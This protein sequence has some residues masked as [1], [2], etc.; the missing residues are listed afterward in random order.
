MRFTYADERITNQQFGEARPRLCDVVAGVGA[1]DR[2]AGATATCTAQANSGP[3]SARPACVPDRPHD[4][5]VLAERPSNPPSAP[6]RAARDGTCHPRGYAALAEFV[7]GLPEPAVRAAAVELVVR[8]A[9]VRIG[10]PRVTKVGPRSRST[11]SPLVG[12]YGI[13]AHGSAAGVDEGRTLG[14]RHTRAASGENE[15]HCEDRG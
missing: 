3:D 11:N 2:R 6:G 13:S 5:P 12:N 10:R 9:A 1:P 14:L 15:N 7:D 4:C 8:T